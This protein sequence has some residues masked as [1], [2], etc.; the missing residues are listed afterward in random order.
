V[1]PGIHGWFNSLCA[2]KEAPWTGSRWASSLRPQ[3]VPS[4]AATQYGEPDNSAR[5][6]RSHLLAWTV[7]PKRPFFC[8]LPVHT[9]I[10]FVRFQSNPCN[11]QEYG[12]RISA[13][14]KTPCEKGSRTGQVSTNGSPFPVLGYL[15]QMC[16]ERRST[17]ESTCKTVIMLVGSYY[18][19]VKFKGVGW[20]CRRA[21]FLAT[22]PSTQH[23]QQCRTIFII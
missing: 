9:E 19:H 7:S 14:L 12:N 6:T 18:I 4:D 23:V 1:G 15:F 16:S 20:P 22:Q 10:Y 21:N 11:Q 5:R 3:P 2:R 13:L 17:P 8:F